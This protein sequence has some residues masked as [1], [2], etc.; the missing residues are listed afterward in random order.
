[1]FEA[2]IE[3]NDTAGYNNH[4]LNLYYHSNI[5]NIIV[6]LHSNLR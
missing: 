1:M 5:Q 3:K 6:F 4:T 2:K